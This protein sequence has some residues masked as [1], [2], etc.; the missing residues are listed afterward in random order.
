MDLDSIMSQPI[1][2]RIDALEALIQEGNSV[3]NK[4]VIDACV[5]LISGGEGN[6]RQ[7]LRLGELLNGLGDPRVLLPEDE[8]YWADVSVVDERLKVGKFPV[9]N[10]EYRA[11]VDAGG[12]TNRD[13]WTDEGWTWQGSVERTW[14]ELASLPS[15]EKF[16]LDNQPVVGI[17]YYEASAYAKWVGARL[18]HSDERV[19]VT[20]G[21]QKRPYPWGAPFGEGNAN[22]QEE[23]LGR[24]CAVGVFAKDQTPEGVCD[25]AGNVAEWTAD[26]V[27]A[28]VL[29]HPGAWNQPSM[30]SWAKAWV[31]MRKDQRLPSLGFRLVKD[32]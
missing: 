12:Y 14:S 5:A 23:V 15:S 8:Q 24:P 31:T 20:R 28:E 17:T 27:G 2:A 19:W 30:A 26:E 29:V 32:A 4:A 9:T 21:P 1:D 11:F 7:R 10:R 6:G 16:V 13:L 18:L 25:L 22:T 3:G